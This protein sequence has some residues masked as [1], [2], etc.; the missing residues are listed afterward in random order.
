MGLDFTACY[1]AVRSRDRRFDGKFFTAVKST[2]I[3]CRPVCT[4]KRPFARNVSFFSLAAAAEQAGFRPCRRCRP[5]ASPGSPAWN[6][7]ADLVARAMRM[8]GNGVADRERIAGLARRLNVSER[9]LC[10]SFT[11][12]LGVGPAAVAS[13]RRMQLAKILI[14]QSNL[15]LT[16]IAFCAGFS[17][18]RRFNE[19]MQTTFK[20]T[21][22]ELRA[23]APTQRGPETG[24]LLSL[25]ARLPFDG[26][27][28]LDF[29][30]ARRVAGLEEID[31]NVYRRALTIDDRTVVADIAVDDGGLRL[32]VRTGDIRVLSGLVQRCRNLF[33]LDADTLEIEASLQRDP[34][35]RAIVPAHP[36]LRVPGAA[37]GFELAV[38]AVVG[39]QISVR[40]ATTMLG[41]L[42]ARYGTVLSEPAGAIT[43]AFPSA[44]RLAE[45]DLTEIGLTKT[46]SATLC[47]LARAV[48]RGDIE[49]ESDSD[50][51]DVRARL[52][53]LRGIGP[54][55]VAYVA[56]RALR[57]PDA[58]PVGDVALRRA[59]ALQGASAQPGVERCW[60]PWGSYAAMHL[61]A[62]L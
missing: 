38:R 42:V 61:W 40:G 3:Y 31:G 29:L 12:E 37:G 57:D 44:E 18:I 23:K 47:A 59:L 1:E 58:Y 17:S 25:P 4:A 27:S 21:P 30:A 60:S 50:R 39:Q 2:G 55:T 7:R 54:W 5:E 11:D 48:A 20:R 14:D 13:T 10:R 15:P 33:D 49:L 6:V 35:M 45:A 24:V 8:I 53:A 26:T 16:D 36:G 9:H 43:H 46:R 62:S 34:V 41:R 56:M 51:I 19:V 28:L 52:L 32:T 22:S